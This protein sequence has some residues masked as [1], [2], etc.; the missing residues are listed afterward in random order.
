MDH[1]DAITAA[2]VDLVGD[3]RDTLL[4]APYR[5]DGHPDHEAMG[6]C[7]AAAAHRTGA[8]LA[9]YPIW[10]WHAGRPADLTWSRFVRLPLSPGA[11]RAKR[12]AVACHASQVRPLSDQ[13][14][15]ETLLTPT[16]LAHFD[17]DREL[18]ALTAAE[19]VRDDR[20]DQL[21]VEQTDPWGA[22]TRWYERRKRSLLL[23]V[24]PRQ[25]FDRALEVGCSTGVLA[26]ALKPRVDLPR[27]DR[28]LA[29]SRGP[30]HGTAGGDAPMCG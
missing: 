10:M 4:V 27:R 1:L 2:I 18:F 30:R 12:A 11:Q 8:L 13:P 22:Q 20:L 23:A 28:Q 24:L 3:G 17:L 6:R 14:G 19:D 26:E 7:A 25:R 9:E 21:H 16:V 29:G 15:D 5:W